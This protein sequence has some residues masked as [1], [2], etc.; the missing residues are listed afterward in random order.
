MYIIDEV[1]NKQLINLSIFLEGG[2][3]KMETGYC[4]KK[5]IISEV[6]ADEH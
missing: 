5:Y 2:Y 3:S 4:I 1:G 6:N